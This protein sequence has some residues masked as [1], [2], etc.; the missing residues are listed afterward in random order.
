MAQQCDWRSLAGASYDVCVFPV[1][2]RLV[3]IVAVEP[4]DV[5]PCVSDGSV[6][7]RVS[8]QTVPVTDPTMLRSMLERGE[9]ARKRAFDS[10][11]SAARAVYER[12][13]AVSYVPLMTDAEYETKARPLFGLALAPVSWP[14]PC[15][16]AVQ[17]QSFRSLR[18][19]ASRPRH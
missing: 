3:A 1:G 14:A 4:I 8:G 19:G 15:R 2:E 7:V 10:A 9:A 16:A 12:P 11:Q 6:Y 5:P 13:L 18:R 17:R